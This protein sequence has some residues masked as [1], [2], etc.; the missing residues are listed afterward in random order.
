MNRLIATIGF[1]LTTSLFGDQTPSTPRATAP[2]YENL[3]SAVELLASYYDAINRREYRRAYSYW[4]RPPDSYDDFVRG[5]AETATVQ[6]IVQPPTSIGAAAGS[7]YVEIPTVLVATH[8]DWS[9]HPF[10]GCYVARKSNL[11]PPDIA[12]KAVWRIYRAT[13]APAPAAGQIPELFSRAC[14]STYEKQE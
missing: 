7:L 14:Q 3:D 13:M 4:E 6:L 8:R 1:V 10:S 12:R 11:H 5:Y 2:E 9:R